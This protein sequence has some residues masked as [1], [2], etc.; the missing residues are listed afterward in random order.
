MVRL[1]WE[2]SGHFRRNT[3]L[4]AAAA[5]LTLSSPAVKSERYRDRHTGTAIRSEEHLLKNI[6]NDYQYRKGKYD[7]LYGP[8]KSI[9]T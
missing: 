6:N 5:K 8:P 2:H 9:K 1:N 3:W 7:P 4:E